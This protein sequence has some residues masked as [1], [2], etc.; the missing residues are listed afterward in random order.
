[1]APYVI[2]HP[3]SHN[4]PVKYKHNGNLRKNV[5]RTMYSRS[6]RV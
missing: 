1:M 5:K 6:N 4:L 3:H 2:F